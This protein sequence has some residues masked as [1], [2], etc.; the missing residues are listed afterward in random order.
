M[1]GLTINGIAVQAPDDATIMEAAEL[2]GIKIPNLC[3]YQK[4][5][6]IGACRICVVEVEGARNLQASCVVK[7]REGMVVHTNSKRVRDARK[8]IY[9]LIISDHPRDCMACSRNQ[10]C[11]L[12]QL[13]FDLGVTEQHLHGQ[14]KECY[15]DVSPAIT[16][17]TTKCVLCRRCVTECRD[18]QG[19][20]AISAQNRG[21]NSVVA[22]PMELPLD[23]T[24][25]SMCGQCTTVCPTGA[26]TET[27]HSERVWEALSDPDRR[28][29]VQTAPAVRVALGEPFGIPFGESVTGRMASALRAMGF[30][31]VF[32]TDWGADLTIMEEGTELLHRLVDSVSGGSAVLPMITSCSPGWIKHCEHAWPQD[33]AHLSSCK[34]PHMMQG[35]MVKSYYAE[36]LGVDPRSLY[37]VSVM[38]CTA[39]KYECQRPEMMRD[40]IADV[41]AVLTTRELSRMIKT[42][43]IDFANLPDGVFD[44]P[45]G[46][47]TGAA[48]IFGVTGGVM[49]AAM[50][51]V[52]VLVTGRRPPFENFHVEPIMGFEQVKEAKIT[53][54]NVLPKF[55]ALEGRSIR[56]AVTSGLEGADIMMSQVHD[57]TSPYTF[58]EVMGCPGGC[59]NGGGQPRTTDENVRKLR[60]QALYREDEG[61]KMRMS[62]ENPAI[63]QIY[64]EYLGEPCGERS[65]HLLHTTYVARGEFNEL[66]KEA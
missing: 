21:F 60:A 19:V 40:G 9:D 46:I 28:V 52:Y 54:E 1:I 10:T 47:S 62:H 8:L 37:V 61:K 33:L 18:I 55:A 2:V 4:I 49:E 36:R 6:A 45:M 57:G 48:D 34:S 44:S 42:A 65:H 29:V 51:T 56:V 41:D 66:L 38:P 32:D 22:P 24:N 30:D 13:G 59:V 23:A 50:R 16:R 14:L 5:H 39:K 27:S 17:D 31:D 7:V 11:E 15:L 58:I 20:G 25:C 35:A 43:G 26:L 3:R 63:Q 64:A 53:F 12:Q